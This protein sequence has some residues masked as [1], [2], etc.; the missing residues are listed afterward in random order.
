MAKTKRKKPVKVAAQRVGEL[1]E[2][3]SLRRAKARFEAQQLRAASKAQKAMLATYAAA[4]KGRRNRDWNAKPGSAD[5]AI[6]P[7][8]LT[9]SARARQMVRDNCYAASAVKAFVRNVIGCGII[10]IPQA[11]DANGASLDEINRTLMQDFW[12]WACDAQTCDVERKQ[13]FWQKQALNEAERAT[14]G[15]GLVSWHYRPHLRANGKIDLS[16]PVG[17]ALQSIEV[18][19]LDDTM[20]SYTDPITGEVR[21]VRGG[22]EVDQYGAAVAYHLYT[23]NPNDYLHLFRA[24]SFRLPANRVF[25][26]FR[27]DR[28]GQTLGVSDLVSVL[29]DLRDLSRYKEAMLWRAIMEACIGVLIKQQTPGTGQFNLLPPSGAATTPSGLPTVDFVPGMVGKLGPGEEVEPFIPQAP[30]NQ[31]EPFTRQTLR[32]V[33]A[34]SGL[35]FGQVSRDFTQGTYSGQR[36]EMLEDRKEFEPLQEL[37]AHKFVLPVYRLWVG[38]Y[39]AEGRLRIDGDISRYTAAEYVAPPPTWIDPKAEMDALEVM[40]RNKLVTRE[41]IAQQYRGRTL[42]DILTTLAAERDEARRLS[43]SFPE[44]VP[45]AKEEAKNP[46]ADAPKPNADLLSTPGALIAVQQMQ[47]SYYAGETPREAAISFVQTMF[48][49]PRDKAESLFPDEKP[50]NTPSEAEKTPENGQIEPPIVPRGLLSIAETADKPPAYVAAMAQDDKRCATCAHLKG[51]KCHAYE[52]WPKLDHVCD[53]WQGAEGKIAAPSPDGE[54]PM[55]DP[56]G[57]FLDRAA[58]GLLAEGHKYSSTQLDIP[59]PVRGEILRFGTE[60]IRNIH[61]YDEDGYGRETQP[62]VTVVYGLHD[63]SPQPLYAKTEGFEPI[64]L[65]LGKTAVF[66][67]EDYDVVYVEADAPALRQLRQRLLQLPNTQTHPT[68]QPHITLAYVLRGRGALY[69][70]R[71]NLMGKQVVVPALTFS[72]AEGEDT[73]IDLVGGPLMHDS[74]GATVVSVTDGM[75]EDDGD[76]PVDEE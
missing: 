51:G 52:F 56:R 41:E 6:L 65:T 31:Y 66:E 63:D 34:G 19:Q 25:H 72:P 73:A 29:Q 53:A 37:H 45:E 1:R 64:T 28:V 70:G 17:L 8:L 57:D 13:T 24:R 71:T 43:L 12:T 76:D 18:E 67:G 59:E 46:N 3:V 7:D 50:E 10:P 40:L 69:A 21:E 75:G 55:D 5:L 35:S 30:G 22:V 36:Q 20:R 54:R 47:K 16:K 74:K 39:I 33:G 32:G 14:V 60:L 61:L 68:Y 58:R 44:D 11:R 23:R 48:N 2:E 9:L 26:V 62:H 38:L 49:M 42:R 15:S 27:Q 4:E